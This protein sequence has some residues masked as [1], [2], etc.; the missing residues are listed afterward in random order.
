MV[1]DLMEEDSP[2]LETVPLYSDVFRMSGTEKII[3]LLLPK[4]ITTTR[5]VIVLEPRL[6]KKQHLTPNC[7]DTSCQAN[8]MSPSTYRIRTN[9]TQ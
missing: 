6:R 7:R 5:E 1:K 9:E 4:Q 3:W 8:A 2:S